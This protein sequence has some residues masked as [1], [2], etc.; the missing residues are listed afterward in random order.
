MP[1]PKT[2]RPDVRT[3]LTVTDTAR[4][5]KVDVSDT[6]A[7]SAK[8]YR[9]SERLAFAQS[10]AAMLRMSVEPEALT[11]RGKRELSNDGFVV[12]LG[13]ENQES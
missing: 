11:I 1:R 2:R 6:A 13:K 3:L 4:S 7:R 5:I 9:D 12:T 8:V 10:I